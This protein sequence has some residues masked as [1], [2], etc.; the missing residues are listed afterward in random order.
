MKQRIRLTESDLHRI[1]KES[2]YRVLVEQ[3]SNQEINEGW[4]NWAMAGALGAA[5]MFGG[6]QT[7]NAQSNNGGVQRGTYWELTKGQNKPQQLTKEDIK[8]IMQNIKAV[9]DNLTDYANF[10]NARLSKL[11]PQQ[12]NEVEKAILGHCIKNQNTGK[13][14]SSNSFN[15][16]DASYIKQVYD[17]GDNIMSLNIGGKAYFVT[18]SAVNEAMMIMGL[19]QGTPSVVKM[20]STHK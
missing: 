10:I 16:E 11:N 7:A 17:T 19:Q 3:N 5:T 1:V 2:V 12:R 4:K 15:L 20:F 14:I 18:V 9:T 8:P 13:L 6:N